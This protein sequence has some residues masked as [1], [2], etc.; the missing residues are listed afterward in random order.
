MRL[1]VRSLS[2]THEGFHHLHR[3]QE[4][5]Y[6]RRQRLHPHRGSL[7][8][9]QICILSA[10][11]WNTRVTPGISFCRLALADSQPTRGP[12]PSAHPPWLGLLHDAHWLLNTAAVMRNR[13][14]SLLRLGV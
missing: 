12:R 7:V 2:H 11:E 10:M 4:N 13:K 9:L 8:S 1:R 14:V 5:N 3:S 6:L